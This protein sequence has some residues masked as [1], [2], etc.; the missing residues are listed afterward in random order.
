MLFSKA[1]CRG[2]A[3]GQVPPEERLVKA[4]S[5]WYGQ[6]AG[7]QRPSLLRPLRSQSGVISRP[8]IGGEE[9]D[10][11]LLGFSIIAERLSQPDAI[12]MKNGVFYFPHGTRRCE[13]ETGA[14]RQTGRWPAHAGV[15]ALTDLLFIWLK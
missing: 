12:K 9:A 8:V 10:T 3:G 6:R 1:A 14:P 11:I 15:T 7:K 4:R 2:T 5:R 13:S